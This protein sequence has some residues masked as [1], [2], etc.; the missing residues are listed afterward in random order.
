MTVLFLGG[1]LDSLTNTTGAITES[2]NGQY[3]DN[4]FSR[5]ATAT[6][7]TGSDYAEATG[8][9]A[10]QDIWV[11]VHFGNF[12]GTTN[13]FLYLTDG[14]VNAFKLHRAS[15]SLRMSFLS[16]VGTW[17]QIG[18]SVAIDSIFEHDIDI[19][20]VTG[21][22]GEATLFL[23]GIERTT[24][25]ASITYAP[26][27]DNLRIAVA[28]GGITTPNVYVSQIA[29]ADEPTVGWRVMQGYMSGAGASTAW[30]G[31]HTTVDEAALNE[32]DYIYSNT[33]DQI[34]T[35]AYTLVGS[36]TGYIP[37]AVAVS[38]RAKRGG[39]GPQNLQLALR[40][41][42]TNYFSGSKALG[43]GYESYQHV[44][45]TNPDTSADWTTSQL[46][47]LQPGVKSIT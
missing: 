12:S 45:N 26:D 15:N 16:G 41:G 18:S 27:I 25:S 20:L 23:D 39:S 17:T 46:A 5:Q 37:R 28:S 33:A 31:D 7:G 13:D 14:G 21:A 2:T 43:L 10:V 47:A 22:S 4:A 36:T 29:V 30:T 24:G 44:W 38:A 35:F 11:H 42:S 19:H 34:E 9:T 8:W 40:S 6:N 3:F 32:A 1:G